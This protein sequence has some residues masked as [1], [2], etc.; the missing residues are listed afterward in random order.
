MP[1]PYLRTRYVWNEEGTD[2]SIICEQLF[3]PRRRWHVVTQCLGLSAIIVAIA[4]PSVLLVAGWMRTGCLFAALDTCLV[5]VGRELMRAG[6][7]GWI[8]GEGERRAPVT[9]GAIIQRRFWKDS[10]AIAF[11]GS[12]D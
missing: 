4:W 10:S 12:G 3:Q 2:T 1:K 8:E 7:E 9:T 6:E 11:S 5:L